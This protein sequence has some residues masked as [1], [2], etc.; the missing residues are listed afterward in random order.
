MSRAL[1][2]RL[3]WRQLHWRRPVDAGACL[4]LLRR[5]ASDPRGSRI[6]LEARGRYGSVSYFVGAPVDRIDAV[7]TL[8]EALIPGTVVTPQVSRGVVDV[9]RQVKIS[10]RHR[11][12]R[13]DAPEA[14]AQ[15]LLTALAGAAERETLTLQ[16][17]LGPRRIPLAIP[18]NSPSS[19]V[20]PW[21]YVLWHGNGSSIDS[22][23]RTALRSKVSDHGFACAVRIGATAGTPR[24]RQQLVR[25]VLSALRSSE[26]PGVVLRTTSTSTGRV[27]R[28]DS[29]AFGWPLR[30]NISE[31]LASLAWPLGEVDLPGQASLHPRLLPPPPGTTGS[32]RVVARS[33]A[34][35]CSDQFLNLAAK[36]A[37]HHTHVVGPTGVGKSVLLGRLIEQ[38]IAEG[39]A[40]VVIEPKGDLVEDVL[41]HIPAHRHKDVVVL[42]PADSRPV[43][44]NPL[45]V[46]GQSPEVVADGVLSVFKALYADSWGPRLQDILHSSLITLARHPDASLVMLPLLLTNTGFRR[47]LTQNLNDPIALGPFWAWYENLSDPERAAA[48]AP[49]M[50]KLRQWLINP[51]LRAGLGQREP[52]FSMR[53]VFTERKILLVPLRRGVIG[54][55]SARLLGALAV[56][57]LW[58]T[59][60]SRSQIPAER[61]HPVNVYIDEVQDYLHLPTDISEALAQARGLGVG[62]TLAHQHLGQLSPAMKAGV[63]ANAR[64][65][66]VFQLGHDDAAT[67]SKGHPEIGP[68]DFTALGQYQVYASLFIGAVTPYASGVTLPSG[69]AIS[70]PTTLRHLSRDRYGRP[71][72][73]VEA[74]FADLISS[75]GASPGAGEDP[76]GRRRR[77]S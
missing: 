39:R 65:R 23:K 43:G 20:A 27:E 30:L 42:D 31:V 8:L 26:A 21:W 7:T 19:S 11:A 62:F 9:A 49:V 22:E 1:P 25:D 58:Q 66:V 36:Q 71:L 32:G 54:E 4:T 35:G 14:R 64:S 59:I 3:V 10:T 52:R 41:A 46:P 60:Q 67:F 73:E 55:E 69:E 15:V 61:R 50:N 74:G 40:V 34:P 38:D 37:L 75:P 53:Q 17:V 12:L 16:V 24:R 57:Q 44:L 5:L 48:I 45:Q 28:A 72:D 63:L 2:A 6:V 47:S 33:S 56:A 77:Q 29:P 70:S 51:G 68:E 18:T 13:A 76:T